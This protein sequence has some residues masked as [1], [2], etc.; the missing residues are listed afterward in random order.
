M[1]LYKQ[2]FRQSWQIT[3]THKVLWVFGLFVLFWGGKSVDFELFFSNAK[4]LGTGVTP[5]HPEFWR[6]D[7]WH[8]VFTT[9]GSNIFVGIGMALLLIAFGCFVLFV[10]MSSQIALVDAFAVYRAQTKN[11]RYSFDHALTA[12]GKHM[13]AVLGVNLATKIV[14]YGL[15][16]VASLPLF[17]AHFATTRF[18]YTAT[19][20]VIL[21]PFVVLISIVSKFAI[22]A[23][24]IDELPVV[25]AFKRAWDMFSH[26]VGTS[27]EFALLS[28]MV[29]V[30]TNVG[31]IIVAGLATVPAMFM[32]LIIALVMHANFGLVIYF[33]IF[34]ALAVVVAFAASAVFSAWH[35][36]NWTLLYV[37]L[38]KGNQRSK[39]HR[40]LNGERETPKA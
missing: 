7:Y 16:A 31:S 30:A 3:K 5:F 23:V 18:V 1:Q 6:A 32:G 24:V 9:L 29:F 14:S 12:S 27:L 17:L 33:Y 35:F 37:E 39:I 26:N 22:N 40:L 28:F 19:L 4:L 15:L 20:Y 34:Y 36:G 13:V 2:I 10:I 8:S 11:E 25:P 21:M 38:T